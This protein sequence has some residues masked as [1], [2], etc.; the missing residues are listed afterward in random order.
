MKTTNMN[1]KTVD[2]KTIETIRTKI[3]ITKIA[4]NMKQVAANIKTVR[5]T[6]TRSKIK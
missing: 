1:Q 2:A 6:Q 4:I 5:S 3:S